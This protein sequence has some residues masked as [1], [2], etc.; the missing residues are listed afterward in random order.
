MIRCFIEMH[1]ANNCAKSYW[2]P[3]IGHCG[4][5]NSTEFPHQKKAIR[6]SLVTS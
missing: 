5:K 3:G 4:V 1:L 6:V 2:N